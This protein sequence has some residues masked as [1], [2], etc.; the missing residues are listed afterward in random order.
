[1]RI[2]EKAFNIHAFTS[3]ARLKTALGAETVQVLTSQCPIKVTIEYLRNVYQRHDQ[4]KKKRVQKN[5]Y[6]I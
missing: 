2:S 4:C 3:S 5:M 6:Y 1:M